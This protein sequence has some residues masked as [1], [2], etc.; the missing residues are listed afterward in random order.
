MRIRLFV[1]LVVVV[2]LAGLLY[3]QVPAVPPADRQEGGQIIT[4]VLDVPLMVSVADN[5][6]QAHHESHQ[7]R[8]QDF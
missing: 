1:C 7:E 2:L 6:G 4:N 3:A 5:K 8:L